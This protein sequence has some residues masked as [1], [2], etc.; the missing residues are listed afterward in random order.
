LVADLHEVIRL[1]EKTVLLKEMEAMV[2]EEEVMA[3]LSFP[4]AT[5]PLFAHEITAQVRFA[6]LDDAEAQAT[7][8]AN[9]VFTWLD[10]VM[11]AA[12][13]AA[14][15]KGKDYTVGA[16]AD[17]FLGLAA[18][19]PRP[20]RRAVKTAVSKLAEILAGAHRSAA[21]I[22]IGEAA[23][24]GVTNLPTPPK[25]DPKRYRGEAAAAVAYH[26]PRLTHATSRDVLTPEAGQITRETVTDTAA[27]VGPGGALDVAKQ[28]IH[29]AGG[30]GRIETA[31]E[32]PIEKVWASELLDGVTCDLCA[33][34]DGQDYETLEDALLDYPHGYMDSCRGGARCRGTLVIQYKVD[35]TPKPG[36][37]NGGSEK[38]PTGGGGSNDKPSGGELPK[39]TKDLDNSAI[40]HILDGEK[41]NPKSGGHR[42][43]TGRPR[44]TEFPQGWSDQKIIDSVQAVV[45]KPEW[46]RSGGDRHEVAAPVDGVMISV[47]FIVGADGRKLR[48][49]FPMGGIGVVRNQAGNTAKSPT[50]QESVKMPAMKELPG[51]KWNSVG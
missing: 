35:S 11:V 1:A 40:A 21:D 15:I 33:A 50:T 42:Y 34:I 17:V 43:G 51:V 14:F 31:Q 41:D 16:A 5:R 7:E 39:P 25:P 27:K 9:G 13:G 37:G 44:K 23:R 2:I 45:D 48:T 12:V 4:G 38:P 6:E 46:Q 8:E 29:M 32:L 18:T 22:L 28:G 24:Q 10:G 36:G 30:T 26:W 3:G 19:Q 47:S 49:A 20:V